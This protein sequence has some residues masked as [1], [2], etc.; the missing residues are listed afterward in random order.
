MGVRLSLRFA[1]TLVLSTVLSSA[2]FIASGFGAPPTLSDLSFLPGDEV[3][4]PSAGMQADPAIVAGDNGYLAVWVDDRTSLLLIP[5][6][7]GAPSY[8]HYTGTKWDIYAARLDADGN[9]IDQTPII[10]TQELLMQATPAVAWNGENWLVAWSGETGPFECCPTYSTFAARVS[11]TGQVLDDPPITVD[12]ATTSNDL[13]WPT[14][15]SD[16]NNWAV[17]WR[18]L[19]GGIW[20]LDA[21]RI[22]PDG[23]VLDPGGVF[24]RHDNVNSYPVDPEIVWAGDEFLLVWEEGSGGIKGQR[25]AA[26]LQPIEG[27]FTI[28]AGYW[29]GYN[30]QVSTNGTDFFV[31]WWSRPPGQ[32]FELAGARVSHGGA[33]LDP[34]PLLLTAATDGT[35]YE[36]SVA[37][38]GTNYVVA[39]GRGTGVDSDVFAARVT[40]DGVVLDFDTNAIPI[41]T[42]NEWQY[43]VDITTA[44]GGTG[45]M[46]LWRDNRYRVPFSV[47]AFGDLYGASFAPDGTV[48]PEQCFALGAP[49]QT[50]ARM[51]S[52]GTDYLV[53]YRS[54][55]SQETRIL[56]QRVD[57]TGAAIDLEPVVVVSGSNRITNPSVAWNGSVY[58][59]VWED[60]FENQTYGRRFDPDL[61]PLDPSSV[62]IMPGNWP[63]VAAIGDVFATLTSWEEPHEV[64]TIV[65][66]R[67]RGSDGAIL[68]L[69]P[70]GIPSGGYSVLPRV[71][72]LGDRWLVVREVHP[73]HD[74]PSS[75]AIASFVDSNNNPGSSFSADLDARA[76]SVVGGPGQALIV[77]DGRNGP[78]FRRDIFARRILPDGTFLD[79]LRGIVV[80]EVLED[81]FEPVVAWDG[82]EYVTAW[83]DFRNTLVGDYSPPGDIYGARVL[84]TGEVLD[85]DAFAIANDGTAERFAAVGG[86]G[87]SFLVG[88]SVFRQEVG[89]ANYRI[90]VRSSSV[91][92]GVP[93][94]TALHTP[95]LLVLSRNPT[96]G[97]VTL[98]LSMESEQNLS[99]IVYDVGGREVRRLFD[100]R[101][102]KGTMQFTWDGL[103]DDGR[104]AGAGVYLVRA[105]ADRFRSVARLIRLWEGL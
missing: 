21:T 45:T 20:T 97:Q 73:T 98:S 96:R 28:N 19:D 54:E 76:P 5:N 93:D 12:L 91:S 47:A 63:D 85:P 2:L 72:T 42:E 15:A 46:I 26:D 35:N 22:A 17:V 57:M 102:R 11:P 58:L 65:S 34:S 16:G 33:V 36:P 59:V 49:R 6:M 51:I 84:D 87:G 56:V 61:N 13:L 40:P 24:V 68:D 94:D 43:E 18:D 81:Q 64:R 52:N 10:V 27:V 3:L 38:D 55:T 37:W 60:T 101:T 39:Y 67:L 29:T 32:V 74:D 78:G 31:T 69:T 83:T 23:T 66:V 79:P 86:I 95:R 71:T 92:A 99:I 80:A 1:A 103:D 82:S 30:P 62:S 25:L 88:G 90:G 104:S 75:Q 89:Y 105:S 70:R 14:A 8:N 9:L 7:F 4:S 50:L 41:S 53:V 44:P 77:V 48:G 100:G